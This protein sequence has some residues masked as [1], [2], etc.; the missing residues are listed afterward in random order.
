MGFMVTAASGLFGLVMMGAIIAIPY[1]MRWLNRRF[2]PSTFKFGLAVSIHQTIGYA[3]L[4][5]AVIHMYASMGGGL[6]MRLNPNGIM[7]ATL[8]L[9]LLLA[10]VIL[11][12]SRPRPGDVAISVWRSSHFVL[13]LGI[14][15]F[16]AIH[17][18]LN[19]MLIYRIL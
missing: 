8:A 1:S 3:L 10:Q 15:G 18:W 2:G 7:S 4:T 11:G 13:M 14:V 19:G 17:V 16:V 12:V 9:L 5:T 6:M